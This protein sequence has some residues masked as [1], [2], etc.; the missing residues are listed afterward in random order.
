MIELYFR[1]PVEDIGYVVAVVEAYEGIAVVTAPDSD[2]GEIVWEV[3]EGM[4]AEARALAAALSREI[5]LIEVDE[6]TQRR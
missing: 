6:L 1:V 5:M 2:C 3:P 4:L